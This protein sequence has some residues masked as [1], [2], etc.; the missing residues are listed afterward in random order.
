MNHKNIVFFYKLRNIEQWWTF[1]EVTDLPKLLKDG[2]KNSSRRSEKTPDLIWLNCSGTPLNRQ[3]MLEAIP[4]CA[5]IQT[6]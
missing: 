2:I 1:P 4:Q 6:I 3:F 5:W